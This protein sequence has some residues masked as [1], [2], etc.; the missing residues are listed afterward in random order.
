MAKT[1]FIGV[2][3]LDCTGTEPYPGEVLVEGARIAAVARDGQRLSRDN[4]EVIDVR[5]DVIRG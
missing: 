4:V 2:R 5:G 1:L 3:I